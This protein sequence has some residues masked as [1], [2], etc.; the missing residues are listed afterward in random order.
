MAYTDTQKLA[1]KYGA[2][3]VAQVS[4]DASGNT[5]HREK[6]SAA[7]SAAE[8]LIDGYAKKRYSVPFTTVPDLVS[9]LC[10]DLAWLELKRG[11]SLGLSE[12]DE[13]NEAR[14]MGILRDISAGNVELDIDTTTETQLNPTDG[15][16]SNER[17][18][19]RASDA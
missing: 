17:L 18:F 2:R 11:S 8:A 12:R 1:N 16:K 7:I 15:F 10:T 13:K 19:G 5:A 9:E 3:R 4:G 14:I 6:V